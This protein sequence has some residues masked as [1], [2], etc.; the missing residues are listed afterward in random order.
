MNE[1]N[2]KTIVATALLTGLISILVAWVTTWITQKEPALSYSVTGGPPL[3]QAASVKRIFVVEVKNNG[4]KEVTQALIHVAL[5]TG[6][7]D[8]FVAQ[9]TPGV[10]LIRAIS[11]S[12]ASVRAD[13]LNP[14][15]AVKVSFLANLPS[16]LIEPQ[17]TVRAPG[18]NATR[19]AVDTASRQLA[20]LNFIS[21]IIALVSIAAGLSTAFLRSKVARRIG[22]PASLSTLR[23]AELAA[24]ICNA[25][26]L[27]DD[28]TRFRELLGKAS[29][30]S[31]SD[32]LL[33][34]GLEANA[35]LK[36]RYRHALCALL[37]NR[38][39]QQQS[40][41]VVRSAID[42]LSTTA[43]PTDEFD[44]IRR[45]SISEA[46]DPVA[47]RRLIDEF[48]AETSTAG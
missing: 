12:D 7:L 48:S 16:G 43:M 21:T 38:P 8:D 10:D 40:M 20:S 41:A 14:G 19:E 35:E 26:G 17:I 22:L 31:I 15:D 5:P 32:S 6:G 24:Y 25:C 34:R 11:T 29:Y 30:R 27:P 18:I 44:A 2:W 13:L 42:R 47:W 45:R 36:R 33:F 1:S 9:G 46:D 3:S 39:I 23:Q 37:L 28:A 4:K